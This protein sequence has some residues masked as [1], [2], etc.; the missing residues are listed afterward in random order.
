MDV[1]VQRRKIFIK[2]CSGEQFF[3][4]LE[5]NADASFEAC[6]ELEERAVEA[7]ERVVKTTE[8]LVD[9]AKRSE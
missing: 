1:H 3:E 7:T 4:M 9:R 5:H 6:T 2:E 8:T